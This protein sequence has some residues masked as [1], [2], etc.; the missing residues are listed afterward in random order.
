MP[1]MQFTSANPLFNGTTQQQ[2]QDYQNQ[3]YKM[4]AAPQLGAAA[5]DSYLGGNL[6]T[7]GS[8]TFGANY[9]SN[10]QAS[11]AQ[12]AFFGGQQ[13]YDDQLNNFLNERNTFSQTGVQPAMQA[14]E[15][16]QQQNLQSLGLLNN[17]NL[18]AAG[19]YNQQ[20]SSLNSTNVDQQKLNQ[21]QQE[22][23]AQSKAGLI[24]TLT[25]GIGGLVGGG[26]NLARGGGSSGGGG[27]YSMGGG[28]FGNPFSSGGANV[29]GG[30]GGF[31]NV[32]GSSL[33]SGSAPQ[34]GF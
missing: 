17:F 26:I 9:N 28:T 20:M 23:N 18:D 12:Q 29:L 5:I 30:G 4:S 15:F 7:N 10:L 6:G 16:N 25:G 13:Y 1:Q 24:S 27:G 33:L 22:F 34:L 14:Q 31:G 19:L 11:A 2:Q 21:Q 3:V 32:L 8:S